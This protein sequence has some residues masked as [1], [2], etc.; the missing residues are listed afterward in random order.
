MTG[1][2]TWDTVLEVALALAMLVALV[3]GVR[4]MRR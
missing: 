3:L 4:G 2:G 1:S